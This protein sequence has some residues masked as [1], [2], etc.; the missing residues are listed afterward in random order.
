MNNRMPPHSFT[1]F[2]SPDH[3]WTIHNGDVEQVL[4]TLPSC[5]Y[6]GA[7]LDSPYG[8]N[9]MGHNWDGSVPPVEVWKQLLRCCKPGAY[10]LTFGSPRT[11]HR[12]YCNIEDAGWE[13]RDT[14]SW[15]HSQGMPKGLNIGRELKKLGHDEWYD[16]HTCLKPYWEPICLA[17][18]PFKGSATKN[19]AKHGCGGLNVGDC[20]M[21][22][23]GGTKRSHQALYPRLADGTADRTNW[24]R[25]G[26]TAGQT[27][28]G[29]FL[30]NVMFDEDAAKILDEQS[31]YSKSRRSLR[32]K[33]KSNIGNGRTMNPFKARLNVV[34]GY[35]DEGGASRFYYVAK[36]SGKERKGNHHPTVKPLDLCRQL[37]QLILQPKRKTPRRLLVPFSGSGSEMIG[38]LQAGWDRVVGI[39][40]DMKWVETAR[41]R[42]SDSDTE[43]DSA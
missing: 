1:T 31:G 12:L 25:S 24:A 34:D 29:R 8:L 11:F 2:H 39:E 43:R 40:I 26:H 17:R 21:E 4:S 20:R 9:F 10:L 32:R 27:G 30:P 37:S 16:Y 36:A 7:F 13:I 6:D 33:A 15:L 5:T 38:A 14:I 22:T 18:K 41:R 19:A 28:A 3:R 35:D 23:S 42:L